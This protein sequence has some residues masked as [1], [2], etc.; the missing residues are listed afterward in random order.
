MKN[1]NSQLTKN[2]IILLIG[3][4]LMVTSCQD[5]VLKDQEP[6]TKDAAGEQA[7]GKSATTYNR[8]GSGICFPVVDPGRIVRGP[9]DIYCIDA[10]GACNEYYEQ[11]IPWLDPC[12]IVPCGIDWLDPWIIYEKFRANPE[13]FGSLRDAA[14]IQIDPATTAA[15]FPVNSGVVGIQFYTERTNMVTKDRLQFRTSYILDKE[16]AADYGLKG[17]VVQAGIYP[18]I[19]NE[20][21]GTFNA[22]TNVTDFPIK[23]D[24]P[25]DRIIPEY[26]KG[27]L[28]ELFG[29]YQV[30]EQPN[31]NVIETS[32]EKHRVEPNLSENIN[33]VYIFSANQYDL[34]ILFYGDPTPQPSKPSED[35]TPT[36]TKVWMDKA[37]WLDQKIADALKIAPF[38]LKPENVYQSFDKEENV[39][40]V[41]IL[42][43]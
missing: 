25:V 12:G 33:G 38:E 6:A 14:Q 2:L 31:S 7:A 20:K 39:L 36:P 19:Y 30:E 1:E 22:F 29:S 35:P 42:R 3:A 8:L 26:F 28:N 24:R 9:L 17:N 41:T 32:I 23:Y 34:N 16:R 11:C 37:V 27:S 15:Q 40:R 4:M 10:W 18:V 5:E 13:V 21:N 43:Q